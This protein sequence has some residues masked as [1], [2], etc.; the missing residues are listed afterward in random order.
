MK[1][2]RTAVASSEEGDQYVTTKNKSG[3]A[4]AH[5]R[6]MLMLD[7]L[8]QSMDKTTSTQFGGY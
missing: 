5:W 2:K 7:I 3:P 6:V 1:N 8:T 4:A